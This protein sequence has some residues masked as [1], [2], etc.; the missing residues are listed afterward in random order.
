MLPIISFVKG[1]AAVEPTFFDRRQ[2][3]GN[4]FCCT[5]QVVM[6]DFDAI[7]AALTSSQARTLRGGASVLSADNAPN[8]DVGGRNVFLLLLSDEAAG[9]NGDREAFRRCMQDY[10]LNGQSLARQQDDVAKR[11]LNQLAADYHDMPHGQDGAFFTDTKRGLKKFIICYMHYVLFALDP[12]DDAAMELLS[13]FHY[14]RG[15]AAHY[16]AVVGSLLERFDLQ[17]HGGMSELKERV[18]TLYENSLVLANFQEARADYSNMR[19]RELTKL[20]TSIMAIAALQSPTKI[21]HT[22]MGFHP[23][24]TYINRQTSEIIATDHWDALDLDNREAVKLLLLECARLKPPVKATHRVATTS[25]TVKM[26]ANEQTFPAGTIVSIP[27]VLG[28]LDEDFWGKTTYDFDAK[29]KNLCLYHMG[30]HSVGDH[31]AGRVC[32]GKEIAINMLIDIFVTVG[33]M[34]QSLYPKDSSDY[35]NVLARPLIEK[36]ND[37]RI[38]IYHP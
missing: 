6:R 22:A 12:A 34:R 20:M 26:G 36:V 4:N 11:L 10:V 14:V 23:L 21:V 30:F 24:P 1:L 15:S 35:R 5:G 27:M 13:D 9:G 3:F 33:K 31:S 17:Q 38:A 8:Q 7:E 29:R 25:F 37:D 28:L 16:L 2:Q 19:R 32:P 18:A